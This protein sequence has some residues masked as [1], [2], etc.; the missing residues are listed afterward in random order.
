MIRKAEVQ[1]IPALVE[2]GR[3]FHAEAEHFSK[4]D[5]S[6]NKVISFLENLLTNEDALVNV[7]ERDGV[8]IGGM[9]A[10][11]FQE[12][13][14]TDPLATDICVFILPEHRGSTAAAELIQSYKAW[15]K[16][17]GAVYSLIS[18]GSG[19]NMERTQQLYEKLGARYIGPLLAIE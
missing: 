19:I 13:Y 5:Y 9:A 18:V 3:L 14:S 7:I 15:A 12:W 4:C 10:I 6:S 1:D 17:K 11:I 2:I 16:E 8:I